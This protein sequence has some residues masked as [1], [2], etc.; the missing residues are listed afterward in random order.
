MD[1]DRDPQNVYDDPRFFAGY[2][3]L[4]RF[5]AGW[6]KAMEHPSFMG[7]LPDVAGQ[8]VLD[9]GCGV[10]QLAYH[11]AELGAA[12][13]IGVDLSARMLELARA[14]RAHPRVRYVR[15]AIEEVEFPAERFELVVSSLAFHYVEDY[16][17]LVRRIARWLVAGGV[18]LYSTEH[19][20][21]T[22]RDPADGWVV[23]DDGTRL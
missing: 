13:V 7:L 17:A 18:L 21:Y 9:L 20:V 4:E 23:D 8:R 22:A 12:E 19:P 5:G 16:A 2:S 1:A 14:E 15:S 3:Q 10:G 11:L 6:T